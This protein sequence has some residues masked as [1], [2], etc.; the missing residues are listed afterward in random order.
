[1]N[2]KFRAF[3]AAV[4]AV[5]AVTFGLASPASATPQLNCYSSPHTCGFPDATDTGATG[6]TF[7]QV[8][9][10]A[11][12]GTGW[13]WNAAYATVFITGSNVTFSNFA[14]TG[15]LEIQG[16]NDTVSNN[17]II[18]GFGGNNNTGISI[19]DV[20]YALVENNTIYSPTGDDR[21]QVGIKDKYGAAPHAAVY[22]NN[23][24]NID[25]GVQVAE[26]YV[27]YN[28]IHGM[29]TDTGDHDNGIVSSFGGVYNGLVIEYNTVINVQEQT[30]AIALFENGAT[31]QENVLIQYNLVA[32]GN[33]T[34]L[35]A[36]GDHG[37]PTPW[38]ILIENNDF[39]RGG[40]GTPFPNDTTPDD[41]VSTDPTYNNIWSGNYYDDNG[42]TVP[43]NAGC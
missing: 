15:N 1:M 38:N 6:S 43:A 9:A 35:G 16:S 28:Y 30:D 5:T 33:Q 37:G 12:S 4:A 36:N 2:M 27:A 17:Q 26:G 32:G 34:V 21:L 19:D 18:D 10:Q 31:H 13:H 22:F 3:L 11:T 40:P 8:P 23:I 42:A 24:Y 20:P 25:T 29:L 41:C 7:T 39:V 14:V